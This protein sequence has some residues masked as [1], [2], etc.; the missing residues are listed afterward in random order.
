MLLH[1]AI[2]A[3]L[4]NRIGRFR[5]IQREPDLVREVQI[6]CG[7][8]VDDRTIRD[9]IEELRKTH[10]K[11][12]MIVSSP[13]WSGYWMAE[14]LDEVKEFAKRKR[15]TA[16]KMFLAARSQINLATEYCWEEQPQMSL[17]DVAVG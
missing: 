15:Q 17:F 16:A 7:Y 4:S 2:L 6:E 8:Q 13:D 11:G 1:E 10:P 14:D 12:A 9:A 5:A 3:V